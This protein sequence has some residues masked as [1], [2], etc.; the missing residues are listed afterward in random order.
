M[1]SSQ[2]KIL[3]KARNGQNEDI[4]ALKMLVAEYEHACKIAKID[5]IGSFAYNNAKGIIL[6]FEK[7]NAH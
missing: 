3:L 2:N 5:P 6:S 7:N 4:E 1:K